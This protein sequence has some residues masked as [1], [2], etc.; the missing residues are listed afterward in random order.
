MTISP[1]CVLPFRRSQRI[2]QARLREQNERP[3]GMLSVSR[4]TLRGGDF[5][6]TPAEVNGSGASAVLRSPRNW[7]AQRVVHF[8]CP[9][10]V[11]EATQDSLVTLSQSIPGNFQ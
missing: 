6:E 7:L 2:E 8:E 3:F 1:R 10:A 11:S 5:I 9:R 4:G